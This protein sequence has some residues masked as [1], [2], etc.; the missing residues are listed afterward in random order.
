VDH[1]GQ[2][3]KETEDSTLC[4]AGDIKARK[5]STRPSMAHNFYLRNSPIQ[6][7]VG[8]EK[9]NYSTLYDMMTKKRGMLEIVQNRK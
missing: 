3:I 2:L 6:K 4:A 9:M 5:K 8:A 7:H 1:G